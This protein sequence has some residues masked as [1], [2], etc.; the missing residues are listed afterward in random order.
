L[1]KVRVSADGEPGF[2]RSHKIRRT[3]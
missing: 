3:R 2:R 1:L